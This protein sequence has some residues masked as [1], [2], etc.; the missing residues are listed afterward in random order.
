MSDTPP[1]TELKS[2][3][4]TGMELATVI[5]QHLADGWKLAEQTS[6]GA[7]DFVLV[8]VRKTEAQA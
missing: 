6:L 1:K 2:V 5:Q 4:C 7:G 8:F 3:E